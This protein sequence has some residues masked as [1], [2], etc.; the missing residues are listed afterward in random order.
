MCIVSDDLFRKTLSIDD[1]SFHKFA[2]NRFGDIGIRSY[3]YPFGE[4]IDHDQ[5]EAMPIRSLTGN[6]SNHVHAPKR[7]GPWSYHNM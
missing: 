7:E 6:W 5:N 1:V 2:H 3:L 4:V